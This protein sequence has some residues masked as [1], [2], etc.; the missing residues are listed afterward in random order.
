MARRGE[1]VLAAR[2]EVVTVL[3][4]LQRAALADL[5]PGAQEVAVLGVGELHK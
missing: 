3:V 4:A 1:R 5:P 2:Q